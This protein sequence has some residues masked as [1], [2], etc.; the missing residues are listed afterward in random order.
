MYRFNNI[1]SYKKLVK[2]IYDV[3]IAFLEGMSTKII[4]N[5]NN[6]KSKKVAWVHTDLS[7]NHWYE[8]VYKNINEERN[9]YKKFNKIIAVSEDAKKDLKK[10]L[11]T[12]I[13]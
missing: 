1:S 13:I 5:S 3:E 7:K 2:S 10:L 8:K 6:S 4:A 12:I 9:I 11:A